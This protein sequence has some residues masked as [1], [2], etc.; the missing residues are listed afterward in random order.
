MMQLL[1]SAY[2]DHLCSPSATRTLPHKP[3]GSS[4]KWSEMQDADFS[5]MFIFCSK[6]WAITTSTYCWYNSLC[7][8]QSTSW[9]GFTQ[10]KPNIR[11]KSEINRQMIC[12]HVCDHCCDDY[13]IQHNCL[14]LL[15][16]NGIGL[17]RRSE[18]ILLT[19]IWA[20]AGQMPERWYCTFYDMFSSF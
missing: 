11:L 16:I 1:G 19:A 10:V 9:K 4:W 7:R 15:F 18:K 12:R 2:R 3:R 14:V 5:S 20:G 17:E 6:T 8:Y 13:S